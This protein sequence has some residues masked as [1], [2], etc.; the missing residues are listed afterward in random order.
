MLWRTRRTN[1]CQVCGAN[2]SLILQISSILP[3]PSDP[4]NKDYEEIKRERETM[5]RWA[6]LG[7]ELSVLKGK[8]VI[9]SQSGKIHLE[10]LGLLVG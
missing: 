2:R 10:E 7:Y 3:I 5:E 8:G 9:D 6:L 4:N 1:Y